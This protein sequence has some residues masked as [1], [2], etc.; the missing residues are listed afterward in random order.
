M[1]F[2]IVGFIVGALLALLTVAVGT[3]ITDFRNEGLIWGIIALLV[4]LFCTF[5]ADFDT[6]FNIRR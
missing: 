2:S 6:R 3:A 1:R 5:V 4:W